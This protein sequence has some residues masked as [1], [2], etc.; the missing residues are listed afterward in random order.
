M[1]ACLSRS[2]TDLF[3]GNAKAIKAIAELGTKQ[4]VVTFVGDAQCFLDQERHR[5]Q[6]CDRLRLAMHTAA[7]TSIGG[8]LCSP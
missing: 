6:S 5:L 7:P 4:C 8:C 1:M 2:Y 3:Q